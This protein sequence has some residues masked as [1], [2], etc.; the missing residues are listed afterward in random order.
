MEEQGFA[1]ENRREIHLRRRVTAPR[2]EFDGIAAR[3]EEW[4]FPGVFGK[5]RQHPAFFDL[6]DHQPIMRDEPLHVQRELGQESLWIEGLLQ[7][8]TDCG[9]RSEQVRKRCVHSVSTYSPPEM[10]PDNCARP[11]RVRGGS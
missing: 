10:G 4:T 6:G 7:G 8:V 5:D 9:E 2:V 3:V 11:A 1:G